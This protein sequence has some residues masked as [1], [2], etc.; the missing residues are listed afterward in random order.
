MKQKLSLMPFR[1]EPLGRG[2]VVVND[3]GGWLALSAKEFKALKTGGFARDKALSSKLSAAG[4][5]KERLDVERLCGDLRGL[6][7]HTFSGPSLH[8]LAV[9]D[10]CN[11]ACVYC[12]AVENSS[13]GGRAAAGMM[14]RETAKKSVDMAFSSPSDSI[15]LEFQ[16]GE[17]LLNWPVVRCAIDYALKKNRSAAR[18]LEISVVTNLSL[19]D[20][21][22]FSF[23]AARGAGICTSLD[24]PAFIHDANRRWRG[25]SSYAAAAGWLKKAVARAAPPGKDAL[26]SAL[27]TTTRLSLRHPLE[28]IETYRAL[29][30]GGIFLRPLSPI[31][32]A[33]DVW[34]EIGYRPREYVAFYRRALKHIIGLNRRGERFVERNAAIIA[35]KALKKED[36]NYL[37]LR[38]PCGAAI[39]QL[40]YRWDGGVYTCDEGR[41]AGSGRDD[42][43]RLGSVHKNSYRE[44]IGAPAAAVCAMAS[45]LENQSACQRCAW[46][47]FCGVC[48]VHNY[49]T[50][51]TPWGDMAAGGWC[52]IQKGVFAAVF[53]ALSKPADRAVIEGWLAAAE[54]ARRQG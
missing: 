2:A 28:I 44:I 6:Y 48:P 3:C 47:P 11:H 20:E 49:E 23:L 33:R 29:G 50:Q 30:L 17:A 24:G 42:F 22:K 7:R 9:T 21:E 41:M 27:M 5:I 39:G 35:A 43:F 4:F 38:S 19:M 10:R 37:D 12:R 36:P 31:G 14:S 32:F 15:A 16:G 45:C 51:G 46:K 18:R 26:P 53:E 34:G 1:F 25:G 8:I 13:G 54:G 40:A 52:E